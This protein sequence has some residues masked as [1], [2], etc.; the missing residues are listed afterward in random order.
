M[1]ILHEKNP[2]SKAFCFGVWTRTGARDEAAREAGICH[3][4]EHMLFKGTARR[5]VKQISTDIEKVGGSMDAFTTKDTMCV[6]AQ[7]LESKKE[8]AIDL[9]ADMLTASRFAEEQLASSARWW[10]KRSA[11]STTRPRT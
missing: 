3:F 11:T 7:V 9:I 4:I 10:W 5:T 1:T 2:I 6:Y 8:I